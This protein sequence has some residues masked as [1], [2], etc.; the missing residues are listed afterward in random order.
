MQFDGNETLRKL[1]TMVHEVHTW[2]ERLRV[3]SL[4]GVEW[5]E[6]TY[7]QLSSTDEP[8]LDDDKH[9]A[10]GGGG[11]GG[12]T[13]AG[14]VSG[15]RR[16]CAALLAFIAPDLADHWPAP[17]NCSLAEEFSDVQQHSEY[18]CANFFAAPWDQVAEA[19]LNF[20]SIDVAH[21][22]YIVEQC[23][24]GIRNV[25]TFDDDVLARQRGTQQRH[26]ET[27]E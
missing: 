4:H 10:G 22:E 13:A 7:E 6:I 24:S 26:E 18:H 12:G 8:D 2:R 27:T 21:R 9:A 16:T 15:S 20:R 23:E 1:P 11:G 3:A 14:G 19:V 25:S 17:L 5:I